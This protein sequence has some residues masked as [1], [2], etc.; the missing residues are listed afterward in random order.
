MIPPPRRNPGNGPGNGSGRKW[1]KGLVGRVARFTTHDAWH[2][3][4]GGMPTFRRWILRT[5]RVLHIAITGFFRDRASRQAAALTYITI[6][7]LPALL[8]FSFAIAKGFGAYETMKEDLIDPFLDENFGEM[9]VEESGEGDSETVPIVDPEAPG[10]DEGVPA[11]DPTPPEDPGEEPGDA[12]SAEVVADGEPAAEVAAPASSTNAQVREA[13]D[14]IFAYVE[15]SNLGALGSIGLLLLIYSAIK[16]LSAIEA[17]LNEIWGVRNRRAFARRVTNYLAIVV[18]APLLLL[19]S[20]A[21]TVFLRERLGMAW[22]AA[23]LPTLFVWLAL[24]FV[25]MVMPNTKVG[26]RSAVLG[27]VV[28]GLGW[29]L[30]QFAHVEFQVGIARWNAVYSSFAAIP[31]LLV[32]IYL[33]WTSF[34]AGAH[35]AYAHLSEP[36]H[37]SIA[38]TGQVDEQY[39]EAL[40]PRLVG[41]ITAAFLHGEAPPD[42]SRL[43]TELRVALRPISEVLSALE[44]R[45]LVVQTGEDGDQGWLPGRDPDTIRVLDLLH[46]LRN[47]ADAG[48]APV[49]GPLDVRVD[50][51]LDQFNQTLHG[52]PPNL[53]MRELAHALEE[54]DPGEEDAAVS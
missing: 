27:G 29:Q 5:Y 7:T 19:A 26:F 15:K 25:F 44:H 35:L 47:D 12:P 20:S 31:L 42:T 36:L 39:R 3:E 6:F 13:V 22:L 53:T 30:I 46:A 32:L 40:A 34:L 51:I 18:V 50:R 38:R 2:L 37:T 1:S 24:T 23:L 52:S 33:S 4:L 49:H 16:M 43:A 11:A 10:S 14:Q 9:V 48:P 41:R 45:R 8:A 54:E 28:A 21:L 17:A